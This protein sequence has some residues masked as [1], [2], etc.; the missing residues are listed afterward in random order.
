MM[1]AFVVLVGVVVLFMVGA[2]LDAFRAV[3]ILVGL[4]VLVAVPLLVGRAG[5]VRPQFDR[6]RRRQLL[7]TALPVAAALVLG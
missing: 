3:Q 6:L 1:R 7:R 2:K 4:D 5:V